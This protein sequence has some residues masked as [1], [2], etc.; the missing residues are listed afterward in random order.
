MP[1]QPALP[2]TPALLPMNVLSSG[3]L[4]G[5]PEF[6]ALARGLLPASRGSR[7]NLLSL[8]SL[9]SHCVTV[10]PPADGAGLSM[11]IDGTSRPQG[12]RASTCYVRMF[13]DRCSG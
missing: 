4:P 1:G 11:T 13:S 9:V 5:V 8:Y 7:G 2:D 12:L 10:P 3:F 6:A